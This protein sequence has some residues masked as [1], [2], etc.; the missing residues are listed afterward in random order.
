MV[1]SGYSSRGFLY[2]AL[3]YAEPRISEVLSGTYASAAGLAIVLVEGV[4]AL[5]GLTVMAAGL[6]VV[7]RFTAV[8][9]ASWAWL[10][11]SATRPTSSEASAPFS[12]TSYTGSGLPWQSQGGSWPRAH[13][14]AAPWVTGQGSASPWRLAPKCGTV[15]EGWPRSS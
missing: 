7:L 6:A 1:A 11:G 2:M 15:R 4:I 14:P 13:E 10:S 5:G 3:G 8:G 12:A 9:R